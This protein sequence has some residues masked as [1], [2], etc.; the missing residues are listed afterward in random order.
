MLTILNPNNGNGK[1]DKD[2]PSATEVD[3]DGLAQRLIRVPVDAGNYYE[4]AVVEQGV[5]FGC[6][7]P[8]CVSTTVAD[9]K[10]SR[11]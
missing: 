11:D 3:W 9:R 1:D 2:S 10:A 8:S 4:L 6:G 5:L 7:R